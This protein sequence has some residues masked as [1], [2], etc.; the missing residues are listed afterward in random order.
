METVDTENTEDTANTVDTIGY[1]EYGVCSPKHL[2][3]SPLKR[4]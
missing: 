1:R 4:R 3:K 2:V